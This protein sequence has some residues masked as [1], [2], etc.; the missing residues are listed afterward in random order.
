MWPSWLHHHLNKMHIQKPSFLFS[1]LPLV[2]LLPFF[3]F[4]FLVIHTIVAFIHKL[5]SQT[6]LN[7]QFRFIIFMPSIFF[8]LHTLTISTLFFLSSTTI[9][10]APH[11]QSFAPRKSLH[12]KWCF[13]LQS[14]LLENQH[15]SVQNVFC[16]KK[17][18]LMSSPTIVLTLVFFFSWFAKTL[19]QCLCFNRDIL[20]F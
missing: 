6:N 11:R 17:T 20:W 15:G 14:Q 13:I 1:L 12:W 8:P 10:S 18:K 19:I 3:H 16:F 2:P 5:G 9:F 4:I 7:T